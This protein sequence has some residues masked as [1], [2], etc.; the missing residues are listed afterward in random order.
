[1]VDLGYF[2]T[3]DRGNK[4]KKRYKGLS[5]EECRQ[6]MKEVK[7][8]PEL[9]WVTVERIEQVYNYFPGDFPMSLIRWRVEMNVPGAPERA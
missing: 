7:Q 2:I 5:S 3:V 9:L 8:D 1:M 4:G 6:V